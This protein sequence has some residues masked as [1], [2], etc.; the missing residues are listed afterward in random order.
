[1][2]GISERKLKASARLESAKI[3]AQRSQAMT[4][5]AIGW[6]NGVHETSR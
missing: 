6:R 4:K 1:V 5:T 3:S 2:P